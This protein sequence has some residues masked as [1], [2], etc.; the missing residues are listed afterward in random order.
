MLPQN[1]LKLREEYLSNCPIC[2]KGKLIV[3]IFEYDIPNYGESILLIIS[4]NKCNFRVVDIISKQV[5]GKKRIVIEVNK[6]EDLRKKILKNKNAVIEIPEIGIRMEESEGYISTIEGLL[7]RI[8]NQLSKYSKEVYEKIK[9]NLEDLKNL[10]RKFT[11]IIEDPE[12]ISRLV[13]A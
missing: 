3:R 4:C 7:I 9:T 6:K 2:K 12:G 5:F 11:V 8:E 1:T 13:E 10:K